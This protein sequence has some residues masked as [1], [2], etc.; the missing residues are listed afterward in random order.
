MARC[1]SP[2]STI[3]RPGWAGNTPDPVATNT[4]LALGHGAPPGSLF[5][6]AP[7]DREHDVRV[8]LRRPAFSRR[9]EL[10][11]RFLRYS[12][13]ERNRDAMARFGAGM[14]AVDA[15]ARTLA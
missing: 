1:A 4:V 8:P 9:R 11:V 5:L 15:V 10:R 2:N 12:E 14:K 7:D 3:P 6:V 13:L